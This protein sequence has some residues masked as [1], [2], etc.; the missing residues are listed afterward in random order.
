VDARVKT[1]CDRAIRGNQYNVRVRGTMPGGL[2]Q[3]LGGDKWLNARLTL[4]RTN[5]SSFLLGAR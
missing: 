2:D 1:K 4:S 5:G 3:A